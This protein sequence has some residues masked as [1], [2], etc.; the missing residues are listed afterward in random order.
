MLN[1]EW[2]SCTSTCDIARIS[3]KNIFVVWQIRT[4]MKDIFSNGF[5][6]KHLILENFHLLIS[7]MR[8]LPKYVSFHYIAN[9][10]RYVIRL[11]E[12]LWKM[13]Q[14]KMAYINYCHTPKCSMYMKNDGLH[15]PSKLDK[16]LWP[17]T[18]INVS[19]AKS[20]SEIFSSTSGFWK[21]LA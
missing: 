21:T 3:N 8:R 16:L 2:Q 19:E 7:R 15:R 5:L 13:S 14:T 1:I 17:E 4:S 20:E 11:Y 10:V 12:C 6:Y 18:K 9:Y